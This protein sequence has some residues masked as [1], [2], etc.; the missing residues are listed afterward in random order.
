MD[1]YATKTENASPS[2]ILL[3]IFKVAPRIAKGKSMHQQS[4]DLTSFIAMQQVLIEKRF[5]GAS[6]A[7]LELY[8]SVYGKAWEDT[9]TVF[10]QLQDIGPST[11]RPPWIWTDPLNRSQVDTSLRPRKHQQYVGQWRT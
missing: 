5:G 4:G 1:D 8:R 7:A 10:R 6:A 3:A 2:H 9:S 11:D